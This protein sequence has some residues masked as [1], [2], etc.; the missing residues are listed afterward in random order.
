MAQRTTYNL[1]AEC[2]KVASRSDVFST[3]DFLFLNAPFLKT[4]LLINNNQNQ[5]VGVVKN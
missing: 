5:Y 4:F 3:G 1:N 2:I